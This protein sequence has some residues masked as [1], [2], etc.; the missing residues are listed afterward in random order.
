M[1]ES[2]LRKRHD[3]YRGGPGPDVAEA[4]HRPGAA[5]GSRVSASQVQYLPWGEA[6]EVVATFGDL[7]A[8][9][10]ALRKGAGIL[11]C[12]HRGTLLVEGDDRHDFLNRMLTQ[13]LKDLRPGTAAEAFLVNRKG[14]IEADLLLIELGDRT[15]I[16]VD[17]HRAAPAVK[18]LEGFVFT[19]DVR[20]T[21]A[22]EAFHHLAVHG[23][24][25]LDALSGA[26]E[27]AVARRDQA[28]VPGLAVIAP[29][30]DV[31]AVWDALL[32][33][34]ARVRPIGWHAFNMARIEAGT[35]LFMI[36]FGTQS[37]PHETGILRDRVSFTKGCYPGQ[38]IVARTE[39]LGRPRQMLVG[40]RPA[41]DR[42]PAAGDEVLA[43]D[44]PIGVVT[45]ST[46]S[47]ML[48]A[49]PV[50]FAMLRTTHTEPGTRVSVVAE[51]E[52]TEATVGD[53]RFLPE[54]PGG[55]SS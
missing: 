23:P 3:D 55:A 27:V 16:D 47:P 14:R 5:T 43:D 19:E 6:C 42:L 32:R 51:G 26:P 1:R 22:S 48:G 44:T 30:D 35:P 7:E 45:S 41:A 50:A 15:L 54:S 53:L 2:P 52:L 20:I 25:A 38:E 10:A 18:T 9:Y 33:S 12:P 21:D 11:D 17:V 39:N 24:A 8:E 31:E 37:L 36:D 13:E 46:L 49:A 29:G 34:G 4:A 40:L 28:G